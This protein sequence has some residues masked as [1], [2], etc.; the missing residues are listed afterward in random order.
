MSNKK[1]SSDKTEEPSLLC[2]VYDGF[3]LFARRTSAVLGTPWS[4][5]AALLVVL[6]WGIT[7]LIFRYSD[8]WQLIINPG[9]TS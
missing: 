1:L 6:V 5:V 9:T 3:H 7:G 8:T 2:R 4:F